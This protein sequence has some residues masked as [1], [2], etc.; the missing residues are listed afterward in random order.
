MSTRY[1]ESKI[2][3]TLKL[4]NGNEAQTRR[5]IMTLAQD[6]P[7]L[8]YSLCAPHLEGIIA[9]QVERVSSGRSETEE[10][11]I[12]NAVPKEGENFGMDLLRAIAAQ[13]VTVFGHENT[14]EAKQ[15]KTASKQHI[16]AIHQM[17]KKT[18]DKK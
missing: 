6:D 5:L 3:E 9:Y 14:S 7:K 10:R 11:G 8:I 18:R 15:R 12:E 2:R 17:A 4:T 13:D 16:D 1:A